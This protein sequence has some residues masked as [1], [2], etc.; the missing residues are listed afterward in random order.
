[1]FFFF[2]EKTI[3]FDSLGDDLVLENQ[4]H[5]PSPVG[6]AT[7]FLEVLFPIIKHNNLHTSDKRSCIIIEFIVYKMG[8]H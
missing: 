3:N 5:D 7:L 4:R 2:F 8:P 1:M 6:F